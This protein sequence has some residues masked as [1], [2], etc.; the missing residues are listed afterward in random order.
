MLAARRLPAGCAPFL[1]ASASAKSWTILV[2]EPATA[3]VFPDSGFPAF[4]RRTQD[5]GNEKAA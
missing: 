5:A 3:K 1:T 4:A 2:R